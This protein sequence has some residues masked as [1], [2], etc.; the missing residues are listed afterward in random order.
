VVLDHP[1]LQDN[2]KK[3][4]DE[5]LIEE[6]IAPYVEKW[7]ADLVS[8]NNIICWPKLFSNLEL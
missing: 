8:S 3:W 2:P 4:W 6:T 1:G 5:K 7:K